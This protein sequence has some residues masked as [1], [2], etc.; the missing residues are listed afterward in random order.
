MTDVQFGSKTLTIYSSKKINLWT[1]KHIL[2]KNYKKKFCYV[3]HNEHTKK[4]NIKLYLIEAF[5]EHDTFN[6]LLICSF[7]I[8]K[9]EFTK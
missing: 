4:I 6:I 3:S 8:H 1:G 5:H 9:H 7:V 2:I